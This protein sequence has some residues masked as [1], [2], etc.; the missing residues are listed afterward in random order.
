MSPE[1]A[2]AGAAAGLGEEAP[3]VEMGVFGRGQEPVALQ[4]AFTVSAWIF[5]PKAFSARSAPV[6]KPGSMQR[7][8]CQLMQDSVKFTLTS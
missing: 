7:E 3:C 2:E 1:A 4:A 5:L 8:W 6:P